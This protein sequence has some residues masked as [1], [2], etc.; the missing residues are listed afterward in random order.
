MSKTTGLTL[1]EAVSSG[2]PFRHKS[3]SE[4][5]DFRR[6]D[7]NCSISIAESLSF[8]WEIQPLPPKQTWTREEVADI[9]HMLLNLQKIDNANVIIAFSKAGL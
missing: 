8:D 1:A 3:W 7:I 5:R 9:R 2:R 6:Y 4:N